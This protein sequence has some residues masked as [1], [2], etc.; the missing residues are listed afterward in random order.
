LHR[1]TCG[2]GLA[3]GGAARFIVD[4]GKVTAIQPIDAVSDAAQLDSGNL[5]RAPYFGNER[6]TPVFDA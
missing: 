3:A 2:D 6:L 5:R 4:D 1:I